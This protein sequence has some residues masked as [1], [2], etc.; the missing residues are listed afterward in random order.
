[1]EESQSKVA[2]IRGRKG[3]RGQCPFLVCETVSG[4][5]DPVKMCNIAQGMFQ[6]WPV[7]MAS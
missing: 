6:A 2:R 1:V 4:A 5:H 3:R 7:Q